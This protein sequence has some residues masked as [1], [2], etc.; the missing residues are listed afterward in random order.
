MELLKSYTN[1]L[2]PPHLEGKL[3]KTDKNTWYK[4]IHHLD[5]EFEEYDI[6]TLTKFI[7]KFDFIAKPLLLEYDK[8][9]RIFKYEIESISPKHLIDLDYIEQIRIFKELIRI[10]QHQL[11]YS[12]D[13]GYD[14]VFCHTDFNIYNI[15]IDNGKVKLIDFDSFRW[16]T[17]EDFHKFFT[18]TVNELTQRFDL[19]KL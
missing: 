11:Q 4:E 2:H 16:M 7:D 18:F 14:E 19:S 9:K 5:N 3:Y 1:K 8:E 17:K 13:L 10:I 12:M 15:F 6:I